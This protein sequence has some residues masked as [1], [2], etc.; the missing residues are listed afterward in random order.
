MI[1]ID[2]SI[3]TTSM[4][5]KILMNQLWYCHEWM[6]WINYD[7][8]DERYEYDIVDERVNH[9]MMKEKSYDHK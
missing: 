1:N 8:V 6:I 5:I 7:I 3:I 9:M 4:K 2:E